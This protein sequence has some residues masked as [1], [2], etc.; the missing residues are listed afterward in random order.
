MTPEGLAREIGGRGA[1]VRD[2]SRRAP[3][4]AGRKA[5]LSCCGKSVAAK[6]E[7]AAESPNPGM[8]NACSPFPVAR[9]A[10][11]R[12][13]ER[14]ALPIYRKNSTVSSRKTGIN[15]ANDQPM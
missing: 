9:K 12:S 11:R 8:K 2:L 10:S 5:S 3:V 7:D 6:P 13:L 1:A 14:T 4:A 15:M